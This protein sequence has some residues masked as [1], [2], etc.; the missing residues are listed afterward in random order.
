ME[1]GVGAFETRPRA[2]ADIIAAW[3]APSNAEAFK[4]MAARSKALGRP[5][6][7]YQ[8][9]ADLAALA[10]EA[11]AAVRLPA[12]LPTAPLVAA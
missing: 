9:V 11:G 4:A 5:Q 12:A 10:D 2:I 6:A 1:N 7:V 3:L 8:I